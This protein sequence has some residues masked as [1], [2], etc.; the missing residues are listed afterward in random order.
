ME[1]L[2]EDQ[3]RNP[4]GASPPSSPEPE[5]AVALPPQPPHQAN[6]PLIADLIQ[7]QPNPNQILEDNL[8]NLNIQQPLEVEVNQ[9]AIN[10]PQPPQPLLLRHASVSSLDECS[11][12][13]RG[14]SGPTLA[15]SN[16]SNSSS[17]C[18]KNASHPQRAFGQLN[19]MREDGLL[20]DVSLVAAGHEVHAHKAVLAA[21]S[22]YFCA[23]FTGFDEKNKSRIVLKDVD[24]TAL[25]I[26]VNYVYTSEVEVTEE[27]V[28]TLLPAANLMQLSDVKEACCEF[29][30]N[31]LHPTNCLGIK[32]FADLHGCLELLAA[33][34]T[35]IESHF[36]EVL[37]CD[38]FYALDHSQVCDLI[39]SDTI[40]VPSEEKVYE[41]VISWVKHDNANRGQVLP[42]LMEHVRLPLLSKE[43]LLKRVDCEGLFQAH[44]ECKDYIIEALKFHLAN[45]QQSLIVGSHSSH[46][47]SLIDTQ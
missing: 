31:Q 9:N 35:Y 42:V 45:G 4:E 27:N 3:Q 12:K 17:P 39:A 20:T 37:D 11:Q 6:P 13:Y 23:M 7:P 16:F 28:Q 22:P 10:P 44:P 33:T 25:E 21:C 40:T 30:L 41:S 32:S 34:N 18:Y 14:G 36:S 8:A 19:C 5:G 38:E 1:N 2:P 46:P 26:L 29:L 24:P 43:Y 47:T 15:S